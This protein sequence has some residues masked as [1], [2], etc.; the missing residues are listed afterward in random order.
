MHPRILPL[1]M[2]CLSFAAS[3]WAQIPFDRMPIQM[4]IEAQAI[5]AKPDFTF[6]TRTQPV[7]VRMA[8]MDQLFDHPRLAAAMWRYC[9]FAP[10]FYTFELPE[11]GL[12]MDDTKGLR[13]TL[14]LAYR[15]PGLRV[16]IADGRVETGR[17]GNPF[18]VGAKMVTVYRYWEGPK[19]FESHLQTW[20]TLDSA[21]LGFLSRPFRGY[22][23]KRQEEFIAYINLC[24]ATGGSFAEIDPEEFRDPIR[25]EGDPV[26]IQQYQDVFGKKRAM[27][28]A[29]QGGRASAPPQTGKGSSGS[30]GAGQPG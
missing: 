9:Q 14:A 27:R 18:P 25:R 10:T 1:S 26:A 5:V 24:I 12:L 28:K 8:T 7:R 17:M 15:Q 23:K 13:G 4:R 3:G 19:G 22:I 11:H 30:H 16:Y 2:V 20:T 6:E 29:P 21:L